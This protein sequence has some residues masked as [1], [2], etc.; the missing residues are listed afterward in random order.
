MVFVVTAL[1][2][3][4]VVA[5]ALL[6]LRPMRARQQAAGNAWAAQQPEA[7]GT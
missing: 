4:A 1:A 5:V 3:F 2:N 7:A 6:V